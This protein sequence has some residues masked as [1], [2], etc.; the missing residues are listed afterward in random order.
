MVFDIIYPWKSYK[1]HLPSLHMLMK[2]SVKG[3]IGMSADD[4]LTVHLSEEPSD[5]MKD[6]VQMMMDALNEEEESQKIE[7]DKKRDEALKMAKNE[8]TNMF[9]DSMIPAERKIVMGHNL[10]ISDLD[11]LV[12]KYI[13]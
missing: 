1:I 7:Q 10:E 5:L 2:S 13:K 4:R 6:R 12:K 11:D 8:I 9:W 3:Y